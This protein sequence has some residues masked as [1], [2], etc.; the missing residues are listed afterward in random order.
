[1]DTEAL[2]ERARK[3][4]REE[5]VAKHAGL[6]LVLGEMAEKP[7]GFETAVVSFNTNGVKQLALP[8]EF[9]VL[10]LKKAPGNPYPDRISVGRARNCDVVMRDPSV[11][12]LHGH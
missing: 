3:S 4:S 1:M 8:A 9:E 12:K 10:A 6:Y 5:F 2:A 7:I 11:S